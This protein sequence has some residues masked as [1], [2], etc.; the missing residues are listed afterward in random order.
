MQ[1]VKVLR[2]DGRTSLEEGIQEFLNTLDGR[3]KREIV[4]LSMVHSKEWGYTATI[5][6]RHNPILSGLIFRYKKEKNIIYTFLDGVAVVV[7]DLNYSCNKGHSFDEKIGK[8]I[9]S[10]EF[11]DICPGLN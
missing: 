4:L 10:L 3:F 9:I 7:A 11:N 1:L 8:I 6:Y 2:Y 5:I